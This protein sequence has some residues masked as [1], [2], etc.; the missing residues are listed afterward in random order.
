MSI[1]QK[2]LSFLNKEMLDTSWQNEWVN[3]P[4]YNNQIQPEPEIIATFK[5]RNQKDFEKFKKRVKECIYDGEKVFDGYQEKKRKQA[6]YP[7]GEKGSKYLYINKKTYNPRFPVYIVSKG[8]WAR[9]PTSE[10]LKKMNVPFHLIVEKDEYEKYLNLV[11]K[12]QLLI[13]PQKYKDEYDT[14]WDDNDKRTGPG[15]ARNFAWNHS[16]QNGFEWHWVMDDNIESFERFNENIKI[17]CNTG[18][19][20]YVCEEFVLRYTNIAQA[21]L[22]YS[23]FCPAYENRPAFITNTR[24]YSCLLIRNDIPYRWRG[25]YNEDTDLSLRVLKDNWCTVQFNCFLQGKRATQTVKGGNSAEFYDAE[26]TLNK[27]TMLEEMHPDV[28]KVAWRFNREHHYVDYN[29]FK[30]IKLIRK[31]NIK[32]TKDINNF[33]LKKILL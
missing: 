27:S 19:P 1:E 2:Q 16:I 6:W 18:T 24:I 3:M 30:K 28:A 10:A 25:R 17:K 4:E 8:R 5:F 26:G 9:N 15:P 13:L 7:L 11:D 14:F 33:G 12:E 29:S 21:G 23:F 31:K 20:F 22:N 32:L